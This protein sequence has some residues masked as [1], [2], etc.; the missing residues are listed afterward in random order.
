M[1]LVYTCYELARGFSRKYVPSTL[2]NR[3]LL[4]LFIHFWLSSESLIHYQFGFGF[5]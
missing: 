2:H 3:I 1:K 5:S 4:L